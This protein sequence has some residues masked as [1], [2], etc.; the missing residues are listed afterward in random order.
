M[1]NKL[2]QEN[3]EKGYE[4]YQLKDGW[5]SY[6][7]NGLYIHNSSDLRRFIMDEIYKV[8]YSIHPRYQKTIATTRKKYFWME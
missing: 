8:L 7:K 4:G 1:K 3:L 6:F 5:T 2:Q